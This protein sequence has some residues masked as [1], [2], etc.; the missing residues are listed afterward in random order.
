MSPKLQLFTAFAAVERAPGNP[1]NLDLLEHLAQGKKPMECLA[2]KSSL[3]FANA[4]QHLQALRRA[5][6]VNA[7]RRGKQIVY[8]L[9]SDD[10]LVL[11]ASLRQVAE[12]HTADA[13][14]VIEDYFLARD[15]LEAVGSTNFGRSY[16]TARVTILD[17]R[18]VDEFAQGQ[19]NICCSRSAQSS[20]YNLQ[21]AG[22]MSPRS[23]YYPNQLYRP[24]CLFRRVYARKD[25]RPANASHI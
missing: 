18:P 3:S 16:R 22:D 12:C 6:L 5:G 1:Q 13:Q 17:V 7:E 11:L 8:R 9:A 15:H 23:I 25:E 21:C 14:S 24:S 10:V 20:V 2:A 19:S 4:S